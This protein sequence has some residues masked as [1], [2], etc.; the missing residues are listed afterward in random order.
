MKWNA[1]ES[2]RRVM[3]ACVLLI[4]PAAGLGVDQAR[5]GVGTRLQSKRGKIRTM[6]FRD[7]TYLSSCKKNLKPSSANTM[8]FG[9]KVATSKNIL[10]ALSCI[11]RIQGVDPACFRFFLQFSPTGGKSELKHYLKT[12]VILRKCFKP[13]LKSDGPQNTAS[14]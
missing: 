2:H 3:Q 6:F 13:C 9:E 8:G 11:S 5:T 14:D 7:D 10:D 12:S 4:G 1:G